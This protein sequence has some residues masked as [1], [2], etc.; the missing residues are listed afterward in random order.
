MVSG[1]AYV[2]NPFKMN[3]GERCKTGVQFHSFVY[4]YLVFLAPFIEE[5]N[6]SFLDSFSNI[7]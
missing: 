5:T 4:E 6:F 2:F 7:S 1:F 3:L